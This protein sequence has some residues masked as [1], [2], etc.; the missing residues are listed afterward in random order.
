MK[1]YSIGLDYGTLSVRAV[2]LDIENGK[3][4]GSCVYEYPHGVMTKTLEDGTVL[5]EDYAIADPADYL[6]GL[7]TVISGALKDA[8]L[9][10][11]QICGLGIDVTSSSDV[12]LDENGNPLCFRTEFKSE[13]LAYI[14]LWKH[15]AAKNWAK[16][17]EIAGAK[18]DWMKW[19][20]SKVNCELLMPKV[21]ELQNEAP[22]VWE[23]TSVFCETAEWLCRFLTGTKY[24]SLMMAECNAFY[25]NGHY[26]D[27]SFFEEIAPG[28]EPASGKLITPK[29]RIGEKAG[30]LTKAAAEFIG[31]PE[32]LPVATPVI[33]SHSS[34]LGCGAVEDGDLVAVIGTSANH[35]FNSGKNKCIEGIYSAVWEAL[36][37]ELYGLEGGQTCFGDA[38]E[39]ITGFC[40]KTNK[41]L[42]EECRNYGPGESGLISTDWFAGARTPIM[43]PELR[44]SVLGISL[45]TKPCD[46]YHSLMEAVCFGTKRIINLFLDNGLAVKRLFA[47]GGI[48]LKNPVM[49]QM[50]SDITGLD[51]IVCTE[52]QTSA[53]GAAVVGA[54]V[55]FGGNSVLKETGIRMAPEIQAVYRPDIQRKAQYEEL[56]KQYLGLC[57]NTENCTFF[58]EIK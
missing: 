53:H 19:Y 24:G 50:L 46:I 37:P 13:P 8:H 41:Q 10:A 38:F 14:R 49:M 48:P 51:V 45:G 16:K 30:S 43:R 21:L 31:L 12:P 1:K 22:K 54:A 57:K 2:I 18:T 58:K 33:D 55:A 27:D 23:A 32:G 7:K 42:M 17:L 34:A 29:F 35:L 6:E 9:S 3:Q 15:H 4:V 56:Y 11:N 36:S 28:K 47:A 25:M 20:G 44:A 26:P 40:G 39:W 5:P 52:S